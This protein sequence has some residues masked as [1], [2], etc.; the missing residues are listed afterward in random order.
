MTPFTAVVGAAIPL[1]RANVDTDTIIRIQRM[2]ATERADLGRWAL[3]ALRYRADGA[4]DPDALLNRPEYAGAPI[5]FAGANFG[6]GSSREPAVWAL[7]G[8]GLRCIV[9]PSFGDI[10][11]GNCFQNGLL[12]IRLGAAQIEALGAQCGGSAKFRVDLNTCAITAPDGSVEPFDVD[13]LRRAALLE[14][15]DDI[16]LTLKDDTLIRAWQHADALRR[17]WIWSPATPPSDH[18]NRPPNHPPKET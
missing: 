13:P 10:F 7:Q 17:P 1:L 15:L 5:L 16:G 18:P 3:E 6:S 8:L 11:F 4:L 14:G 2:L 9:A 12:P